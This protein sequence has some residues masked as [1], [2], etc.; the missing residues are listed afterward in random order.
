MTREPTS[1]RKSAVVLSPE[2]EVEGHV[3]D[4][5]E[6]GTEK[7]SPEREIVYVPY[8][9]V[10]K[11]SSAA[12]APATNYRSTIILSNLLVAA[13][14]ALYFHF[15]GPRADSKETA[16][17]AP[18]TTVATTSNNKIDR[19]DQIDDSSGQ[20]S[21]P[22]S[23][24][25][26]K[27]DNI[28]SD[29][30]EDISLVN[31]FLDSWREIAPTTKQSYKN[32]DWFQQ[33]SQA[34]SEKITHIRNDSPYNE[35]SQIYAGT[36]LNLS[37]LLGIQTLTNPGSSQFAANDEVPSDTSDNSS[38]TIVAGENNDSNANSE[39][40][41]D[42]VLASTEPDEQATTTAKNGDLSGSSQD[43]AP[44]QSLAGNQSQLSSD[45]DEITDIVS[46][47]T[48]QIK[49]AEAQQKNQIEDESLHK[50]DLVQGSHSVIGNTVKSD[51]G[52]SES[53]LHYLLG[54]YATTYEFGDTRKLL[55]LFQ[56]EP[57]YRRALKHNFKKVFAYSESRHIEFSN[58]D[59]KFFQDNIVGQ[60]KYKA[61]IELKHNKGT[62][63]INADVQVTM[64][65]GKNSL[66]IE[67]LDF[68][69][70]KSKTIKPKTAKDSTATMSVVKTSISEPVSENKEKPPTTIGKAYESI[71]KGYSKPRGPTA[72]ELQDVI[73][74]FIGAYES[75]NIKALDGIFSTNARTNDRNSLREIKSDYKEFFSNTTDRQLYIKDLKWTF[76]KELA[77]GI[78][79]LNA[80][81][82]KTDSDKINAINGEI[83]IVAQRIK[84][85][86]LITH[87][88]HN[89]SISKN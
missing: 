41:P 30:K 74:R 23:Q 54:Q 85:K 52:Y 45:P 62:R 35:S 82:V 55:A 63:Y 2:G 15:A 65:P 88:F 51:N 8:E 61:T 70:V 9:S 49:Q 42:T 58:L 77:K 18:K 66:K 3:V 89:Y 43:S 6:P 68:T 37:A 24:I 4:I 64:L 31:T 48:S 20:F 10:A 79:N 72:A 47:L 86:V 11:T 12:P 87:L 25:K 44:A 33:F 84:D 75:G 69:K 7:I 56:A 5:D 39:S 14:V 67:R 73:T 57:D 13:L 17:S 40:A 36:L 53:D 28:I 22:E 71:S 27:A 59:W 34:L 80:L 19:S 29:Q 16:A 46:E 76:N 32:S 78:G 81:V 83:E 21:T 26:M 60:G 38:A 50:A 1:S